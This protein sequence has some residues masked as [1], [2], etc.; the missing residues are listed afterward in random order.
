[1]T[2]FFAW[3]HDAVSPGVILDH[4]DMSLGTGCSRLACS[5]RI[6]QRTSTI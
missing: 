2:A 3:G 1:M 4:F 5:R 6:S